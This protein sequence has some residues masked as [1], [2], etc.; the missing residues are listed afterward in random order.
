MNSSVSLLHPQ[1]AYIRVTMISYLQLETT[2][3]RASKLSPT[4]QTGHSAML[5]A[6]QL[7]LFGTLCC[8]GAFVVVPSSVIVA[9]H[10]GLRCG[11]QERLDN[12]LTARA[13]GRRQVVSAK[14]SL[15][16]LKLEEPVVAPFKADDLVRIKPG[17]EML[18][19]VPGHK[20]GFDAA[21]SEGKVMRIYVE[22]NLSCT[23]PVKVKFAEPKNWVGHFTFDELELIE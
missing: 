7:A 14:M 11:A 10:T 15:L 16:G 12:A 19:H 5:A 9:R 4:A 2:P 8:A 3:L 6:R 13:A 21:G 22:E 23:H 20:A 18:R 1:I 17:L